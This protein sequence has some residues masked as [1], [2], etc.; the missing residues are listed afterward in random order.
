MNNGK[1]IEYTHGGNLEAARLN[2]GAKKFL[3]LSVN[4]NPWGPPW[5]MW[6]NLIVNLR[7]I[8]E[9]PEPYSERG[10]Q[11]LA[12]YFNLSGANFVLGNGAAEL[13]GALPQALPVERAIVLEPAFAEYRR[14]FEAV[15]KEVKRIK[16]AGDFTIPLDVVAAELK[17]GDLLFVCQPNN[18]NG[19]LFKR[20]IL[21]EL[22]ELTKT[23][24]SWLVID[25]SFLWFCDEI[26]DTSFS[27]LVNEYPLIIINSLTKIAA[28][29]GL[30]LGFAIGAPET[31][32]VIAKVLNQW[33]LNSLAQQIINSIFEGT[34]LEKTRQRLA[35]ESIWL[36]EKLARIKTLKVY[37]WDANFYLIKLKDDM[38]GSDPVS[39]LADLGILVR[40]CSNFEGLGANF[41]RVAV[42]RRRQNRRL[43]K[44]LTKVAGHGK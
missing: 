34:F 27:C 26:L 32:A 42:G 41:I 13:I 25:E 31:I 29:P 15:G 37:P 23:R 14:A 40:D 39:K 30:R 9:Y 38:A 3:D 4:L 1:I 12:G 7:R 35:N 11:L 36:Q 33:N 21:L 20:E 18:P 8:R 16:L 6:F 19:Q 22:L 28:I 2:Y 24:G 17:K 43:I 5:P 10:R 44:A